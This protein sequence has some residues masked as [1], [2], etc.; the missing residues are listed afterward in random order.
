[1]TVF[2]PSS[3]DFERLAKVWQELTGDPP[4]TE[5]VAAREGSRSQFGVIDDR[6]GMEFQSQPLRL[7]W[8]LVPRPADT[9]GA[10]PRFDGFDQGL[11]RLL[12]M[13]NPWLAANEMIG[14]R[15]ALGGVMLAP[16][17]DRVAGYSQLVE[18]VPSLRIDPKDE[19]SDL[20]F[21]INRLK[22]SKEVGDFVN[23]IMRWSVI[24]GQSINIAVSMPTVAVE[25]SAAA[26]EHFLRLEVDLN[27]KPAA[28]NLFNAGQMNSI[29][30]EFAEMVLQIAEG[31]EL[32]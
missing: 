22:P 31:G 10:M 6:Y 4:E 13:V 30:Q 9:V 18:L 3:L 23:R 8:H 7:D 27:T 14:T 25:S 12:E 15:I 5:Q 17:A 2:L 32:A 26:V 29:F 11:W 21:Q 28:G 19:I 1:M 20:F 16:V 24:F